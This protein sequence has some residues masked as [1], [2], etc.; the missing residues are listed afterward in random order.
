MHIPHRGSGDE[1]PSQI[2]EFGDRTLRQMAEHKTDQ[3]IADALFLSRRT[4]NWH[5]RSILAKL[6]DPSRGDAVIKAR[7]D[8]LF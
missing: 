3:Q 2:F 6:D 8:G 5:V 1:T 4:V 7:A